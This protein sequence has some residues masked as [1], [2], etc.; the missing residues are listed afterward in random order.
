[1]IPPSFPSPQE[2]DPL[3]KLD[4]ST[5]EGVSNRKLVLL[6]CRVTTKESAQPCR[7]KVKGDKGRNHLDVKSRPVELP[8]VL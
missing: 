6:I 7:I 1:M 4:E 3:R 5:V 8:S 2:G